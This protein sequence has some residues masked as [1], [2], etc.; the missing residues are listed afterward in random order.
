MSSTSSGCHPKRSARSWAVSTSGETTLTQVSPL[1][2]SSWTTGAGRTTGEPPRARERRMRGRL[3]MGTQRVVLR[4]RHVRDCSPGAFPVRM[5]RLPIG[6]RHMR[7]GFLLDPDVAYFNHGGYGGCPR[8][9]CEEY[10]RWQRELEREPTQHFKDFAESTTVARAA[11]AAFVG[12]RVAD[13]V[14]TPNATS[15]LNAVI[16]SLRIRPNEEVLTTKHE[17]GAIL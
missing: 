4:Q 1:A 2:V 17:Y 11:L 14:F 12:S 5:A 8:E 15:A 7:E 3:G 9:V 16:R 10:Q 13:I 6:W